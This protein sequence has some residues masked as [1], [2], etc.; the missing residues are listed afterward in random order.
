[1]IQQVFRRREEKYIL[2][3]EQYQNLI[4]V[5]EPYLEKDKYFVGTNCSVYFDTPEWLLAIRSLEKP[6]YKEK[7]RV[8]SYGTPTIDDLVFFEIKKKY[9]GIGSKRRV[10][11]KLRDFYDF[12]EHKNIKKS[13]AISRKR[14]KKATKPRAYQGIATDNPQ[15]AAEIDYCFSRYELQPALFIAYDR[16]SYFEKGKPLFRITFDQNIR[17]RTTDLRLDYGDTGELY[18]E[19]GEIVMEVKAINAYPLWFVHAISRLKI[20]PASF[21]KYGRIIKR[22]DEIGEINYNKN[23]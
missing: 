11:V 9:N 6:I 20:Y 15:I 23:S 7:V 3:Q 18:F 16:L 21:S 14:P 17:Y 22:L 13:Q 4:D 1:M 19:N 5:I 10:P 12:I 2:S 8:R